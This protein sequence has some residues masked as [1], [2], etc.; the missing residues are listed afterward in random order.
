MDKA[1][2]KT[3]LRQ[4]AVNGRCISLKD[5]NDTLQQY[6]TEVSR[7]R[8]LKFAYNLSDEVDKGGPLYS[9]EEEY[10]NWFKENG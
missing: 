7:E 8:A 9:F 2:L 5:F 3:R 1:E 10:D 4:A 6:A